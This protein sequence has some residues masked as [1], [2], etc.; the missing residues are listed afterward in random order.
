MRGIT[1]P[2]DWRL[3]PDQILDKGAEVAPGKI[4][5]LVATSSPYIIQELKRLAATSKTKKVTIIAHSNGGLVTKRLIEKLGVDAATLVDK[6]IFVA[7][8][9]WAR[10]KQSVRC[11]TGMIRDYL[12][13][14][15]H[16][17]FQMVWRGRWRRICR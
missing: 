14:L 10:R 8:P 12:H 6:V 7:V 17:G 13:H 16:T 9:Q 15:F 2:Y 5:Y 11:F 1:I 4:S 3:T